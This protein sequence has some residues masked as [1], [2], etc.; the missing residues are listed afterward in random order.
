MTFTFFLFT[1]FKT[2]FNF[3]VFRF[4][5]KRAD[6]LEEYNIKKA[7]YDRKHNSSGSVSGQD[8]KEPY[9]FLTSSSSYSS[10]APTKQD[11]SCMKKEPH[12]FDL[13]STNECIINNDNRE[14]DEG[15]SGVKQESD[16]S[17]E[18]CIEIKMEYEAPTN[19]FPKKRKRSDVDPP[20]KKQKQCQ[21]D[22]LQS[23]PH[24]GLTFEQALTRFPQYANWIA[25][26]VN[27]HWS[28]I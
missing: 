5:Q 15:D 1:F 4:E 24:A 23:G 26:K 18:P 16:S 12:D 8:K 3:D 28:Q 27:F 13:P 21:W 14:V 6:L 17:I 20:T 7:E 2:F 19:D 10:T 25:S 22:I 9:N 11:D